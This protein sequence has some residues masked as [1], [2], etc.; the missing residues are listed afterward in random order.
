MSTLASLLL[1]SAPLGGAPAAALAV[2]GG[3]AAGAAPAKTP[4]SAPFTWHTFK[5]LNGWASASSSNLR[6]G[7]PAWA[8]HDGVVYFRGAIKNPAPSPSE[9]LAQLPASDSPARVLY[10]EVY[11]S[12]GVAGALIVNP[13]G[14]VDALDG[15]A[16]P[17]TSLAGVSYPLP[18]I[19]PHSLKPEHGWRS[20]QGKY[21]T[22]DPGYAISHGVVYLSGSLHHG[23]K[24]VALVLPKAARPPHEMYRSIYTFDGNPGSV[25][26]RPNGQVELFGAH[27]ARFT[28]LAAIS[29]P[30]T[31]TNW[32]NFFLTGGWKSGS[33]RFHSSAPAYT[34]LNGV[35]YL[36]GTMYQTSGTNVHWANFPAAVRPAA[37]SY[38][39]VNAANATTGAITIFAIGRVDSTPFADA[40][41]GTSLGGISYPAGS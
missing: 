40:Q 34:T 22:G 5:L 38:L 16:G 31:G 6:T 11:T 10:I 21:G 36:T 26:I 8:T 29:Y 12:A 35:V 37:L 25:V 33:T 28:S 27:A 19:K 18:S 9:E 2:I 13:G 3:T 17:F 41:G 30:V 39:E 20:D 1:R 32:H 4:T 23:N 15:N 14:E 24:P 7:T